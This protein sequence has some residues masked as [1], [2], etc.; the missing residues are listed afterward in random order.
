MPQEHHTGHPPQDISTIIVSQEDSSSMTHVRNKR[1][2][3][4]HMPASSVCDSCIQICDSF[5]STS[6]NVIV[7]SRISADRCLVLTM[8]E[9]ECKPLFLHCDYRLTA[10]QYAAFIFKTTTL[11]VQNMMIQ[12]AALHSNQNGGGI[13]LIAQ[14]K[15]MSV[16]N[17]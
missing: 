9:S 12:A 2:K 6:R 1:E 4:H 11:I 15:D 8:M 16:S 3:T 17:Q 13:G 14:G 7:R 10:E 5:G